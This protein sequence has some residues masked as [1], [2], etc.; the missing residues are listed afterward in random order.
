LLFLPWPCT[1]ALICINGRKFKHDD[2]TLACPSEI[3]NAPINEGQDEQRSVGL[4]SFLRC[5]PEGAHNIF[6]GDHTHQ[7]MIGA[8]DRKLRFLRPPS[9]AKRASA[10]RPF[11]VSESRVV[12]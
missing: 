2:I 11:S 10:A 3:K 6:S 7:L 1:C 12:T 4:Y 5:L 8:Y 9:I